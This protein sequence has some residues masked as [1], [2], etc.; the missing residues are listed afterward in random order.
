MVRFPKERTYSDVPVLRHIAGVPNALSRI[1]SSRKSGPIAVDV[2]DEGIKVSQLINSG[3]GI[4]LIAGG[5][6]KQ[7]DCIKL[8]S[9]DWQRWAI[10]AIRELTANGK[11]KGRDVIAAMPANE[12]FIDHMKMPKVKDGANSDEKLRDALFSKVK[13]KLPFDSNNAMIRYIP[14]EDNNVVIVAAERRLVERHLAIYENTGLQIKSIGVWPVALITT[15]TTFFGRRKA[16]LD[17][18]VML[19]QIDAQHT[20]VVICR[21][22]NLLFARSIPVG[23]RQLDDEDHL[24]RLVKELTACRRHFV[25]MYRSAQIE[26][27]IFFSH[28]GQNNDIYAKIAK[29]VEMPAQIGDC[30]AAVKIAHPFRAGIDRRDCQVSWATAFGLGLS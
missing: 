7:P 16:D 14:A 15:Y 27:L 11:F 26:R 30:L 23:A 8:G 28:Q 10:R 12:V 20:N 22:K 6:R 24:A 18:V 3:N 4:S 25:S 1:L 9:G 2:G 19:L 21:H 17:V 29:Q 13:Q 5:S